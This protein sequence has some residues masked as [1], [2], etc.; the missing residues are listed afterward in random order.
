MGELL[1][2]LAFM[3]R[4]NVN[5]L[6]PDGSLESQQTIDCA[7]DDEAIDRVGELDYPYEIDVWEGERHVARFP[8]WRGPR[9]G[10]GLS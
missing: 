4:Y 5:L 6:A 10:P 7:H 3:A 2:P 8:P 9:F 1:A